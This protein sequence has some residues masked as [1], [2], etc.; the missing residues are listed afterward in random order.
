M[1]PLMMTAYSLEKPDY[2][3]HVQKKINRLHTVIMQREG[4]R[5]EKPCPNQFQCLWSNCQENQKLTIWKSPLTDYR[6]GIK[7]LKA[8]TYM[9]GGVNCMFTTSALERGNLTFLF[10]IFIA[11]SFS[12]ETILSRSIQK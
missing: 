9:G 4:R 6:V 5:A 1:I 2:L 7:C 11:I 8:P 10:S 12:Q 3:N